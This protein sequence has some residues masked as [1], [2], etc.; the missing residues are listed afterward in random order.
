MGG[1][2][3]AE[4]GRTT[5]RRVDGRTGASCRWTD[6]RIGFDERADGAG[7]GGCG[8]RQLPSVCEW[9][10][11][12]WSRKKKKRGEKKRRKG[13]KRMGNIVILLFLSIL[14][15]KEKPFLSNVF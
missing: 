1:Q 11:A 14:Y 13:K 10:M 9:R 7:T 8:V 15:V 4:D 6:E 2:G 5:D 12:R 3:G